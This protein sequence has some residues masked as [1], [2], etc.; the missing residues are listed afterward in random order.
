M[1]L[2]LLV[3]VPAVCRMVSSRYITYIGA[4]VGSADDG[5]ASGNAGSVLSHSTCQNCQYNT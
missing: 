5:A 3:G 4:D 2:V 1:T